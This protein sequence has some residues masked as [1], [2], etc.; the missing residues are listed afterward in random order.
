MTAT[1]QLNAAAPA[2]TATRLELFHP[3]WYAAVMGTAIVGIVAYQ[4]PGHIAALGGL[5]RALGVAMTALAA[6]LAVGL[7]V[8]YVARWLRYPDAARRDFG[9][10]LVGA[11]YATFPAGLL[12][13]AVGVATVGS[14]VVTSDLAFAISG[15]LTALGIALAVVVSVAFTVSLF[16]GPGVEPT[17]ANGAWFIP[18]VV[19]II[20]PVALVPFAS[21]VGAPS[22][23]L[24]LLAGYATWGVGLLLFVLVAA[25]L[26]GRLA[27]HPLPGAPLAPS[28]WIPLGPAGAGGLALVRLAQAG[29]PVWGDAAPGVLALSTIGATALWGFGLWW[30]AVAV[31]LLVGY[32]RR[33]PL[34]YGVGWWAFT[35]PL[36]A[37][38]ALTVALARAWNAGILEAL[39]ALLFVGLVAAWLIVAAGTVSAVR[40]GAAWR[41]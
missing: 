4:E 14:A 23:G 39:A 7:G 12:V 34:P 31:A 8:P 17:A 33:G 29:G 30:L 13:L 11:L 10:P 19:M 40:S 27:M 37:F 36:G 28:L 5:L 32:R 15:A 24:V 25:V 3:G 1:A 38:T 41:R 22:A 16:A 9:N 21:R 35:F 26:Y 20:V 2:R 6:L 18:P